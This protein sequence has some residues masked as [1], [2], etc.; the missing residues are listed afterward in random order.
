MIPTVESFVSSSDACTCACVFLAQ[1]TLLCK[2]LL[3]WG[4]R[5]PLQ[6]ALS[7]DHGL[8]RLSEMVCASAG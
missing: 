2:I 6:P 5:Y 8:Q 4:E 3:V 1:F 7:L